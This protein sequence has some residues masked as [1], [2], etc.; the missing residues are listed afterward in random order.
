MDPTCKGGAGS[1]ADSL[2]NS[3][4][5]V[6]RTGTPCHRSS[7]AGGPRDGRVDRLAGGSEQPQRCPREHPQPQPRH[8]QRGRRPGGAVRRGGR[9]QPP[10][11]CQT[12]PPS[13][14][15][16]RSRHG[17]G[18]MAHAAGDADR[19]PLRQYRRLHRRWHRLGQRTPVCVAVSRWLSY[20]P[21]MV[22]ERSRHDGS[23]SRNPRSL[24]GNRAR[25][26]PVR[27]PHARRP[28]WTRRDTDRRHLARGVV[29]S[30]HRHPIRRIS[31]G[32]S[33]GHE[34]GWHRRSRCRP[35]A[36][37]TAALGARRGH[38]P[39]DGGE[40]GDARDSQ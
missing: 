35:G 31:A 36:A 3:R 5:A 10:A 28:R 23:L 38:D 30:D 4:T 26:A 24:P 1:G 18:G 37:T 25:R 11:T 21:R 32:Q 40:T 15:R 16:S 27:H 13:R 34:A 17:A 6:D 8:R 20:R 22:P 14:R 2:V 39:G 29:R 33:G 12:T 19:H 9:S 7:I